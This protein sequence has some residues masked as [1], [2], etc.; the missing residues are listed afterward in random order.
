MK[1]PLPRNP[2]SLVG[3][4][5]ATLGAVLFLI[6][7][8][9]DAFGLHSNPYMGIVF[10]IILPAI[11]VLGLLLIPIGGWLRRRRVAAGKP[12]VWPR[13][14][15]NNPHHRSVTAGIFV[16]TLINIVIVSM[17]AYTGIEVMDSTAFCGSV[18]HEVMQP[19]Y[20]AFEAGAHARVGCVGCHIGPGASW[21]VKSKLSGTRQVFAVA[22]N[23]HDRPIPSPVQN[24]RPA[25]ET[26]EQCHWPERFHGDKVRTFREYG[27]DEKNTVNETVMEMRIGGGQSVNKP[28]TG[29]HWHTSASTEIEYITTDAKRQVIPWVRLKDRDGNV[30]EYVAEGVTQAD[31]AKGELRRMDCVDCH[32]RPGHPF[33]SSA[34]KAVDAAL[35][36]G[37]LPGDLPFVRR[38]SVAAVKGSYPNQQT[39]TD[40]IAAKIREFYRTAQPQVYMT[41]RPDVERAAV[42]VQSIYS[43]NVF[44]SMNV[45]F[46]TYPNN[47]GHTDFPGCFRCHDDTH[48]SKE[49]KVIRQDCE[50]CHAIK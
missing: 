45:T 8:I 25:R 13:I 9:A 2:I 24:L 7:F 16:L 46:G 4:L 30:R 27:D 28:V 6:F 50:L 14:D 19:Q 47:I 11:F 39:A 5:L 12:D 35:S 44:P 38:E 29:I 43:R 22:L 36:V 41:R 33:A 37:D 23:T 32:N 34:E 18:C 31:L 20:Q 40:A 26:C 48:K 3:V 21:F 15:L 10:F 17:A 1:I 42:A 49:G